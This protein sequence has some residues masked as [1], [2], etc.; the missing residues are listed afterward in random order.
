MG[1]LNDP[2]GDLVNW[3]R[4]LSVVNVKYRLFVDAMARLAGA[5]RRPS[6]QPG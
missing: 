3:G 4:E 2:W 6:L 5:G 1:K